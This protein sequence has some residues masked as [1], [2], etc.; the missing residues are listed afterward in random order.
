MPQH[1]KI[2]TNRSTKFYH[3][4]SHVFL[5]VEFPRQTLGLMVMKTM[6]FQIHHKVNN[7]NETHDNERFK[8]MSS[9]NISDRTE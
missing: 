6:R 5:M 9:E 7:I 4:E 3:G 1:R 2:S 8:S